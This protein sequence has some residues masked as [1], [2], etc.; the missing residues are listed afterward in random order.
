MKKS[1]QHILTKTY[2]GQSLIE[3]LLAM[4]IA[5]IIFPAVATGIIT[6]REGRVQQRQRFEAIAYMK[7]AHEALRNIRERGWDN[8]NSTGTYSPILNGSTWELTPGS[9]TVDGFTIAIVMS[10]VYRDNGAIVLSTPP[11]I[12]DPSTKRATITVSW[13]T[14]FT[15]SVESTYYLTRYLENDAYIETTLGDF[16]FLNA[17]STPKAYP[18]VKTGVTVNATTSSG[19]PNDGEV[20]LGAGG[21]SD[22]CTPSLLEN[23]LDLPGSGYP[24]SITAIEGKAFAGTGENASGLSFMDIDISNAEPPVATLGNTYDGHKSNEVF[25]EVNYGYI[26]TDTNA[27]EV[28]IIDLTGGTYTEAG[29][30]NA[31][32]N[33]SGDALFVMGNTGYMTAANK[34]YNFDVTSKTGSRPIIDTDGVTL[35]GSG[36]DMYIVNN[37]AYV[38]ISGNTSVEMQIIDLSNP[39]N[40]TVINN[41]NLNSASAKDIYVNSDG[42]RAYIA[43]G[44][45]ASQRE[46]FIVDVDPAS[47]TYLSVMGTFDTNGMDPRGITVVP[48]N[49]LIIVG[50]GGEEYQVVRIENEGSPTYCEGENLD[51]G[52]NSVASILE[53]DGDAYSYIM[54]G[55][56]D[57]EFRVIE[58]GPGGAYAST[59]IFESATF[60]PGYQTANN[61]FSASFSEPSGTE[62]RFQVALTALSGGN[63]PSTGSYTFIGPDGTSAS[64]FEPNSGDSLAFPLSTFGNY[65]NPGQCFRYRAYMTTSNINSTPVL[66]D[67]TINYSP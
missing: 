41:L 56:A 17:D 1:V 5:A 25:G 53:S 55:D 59:G 48:G 2:K 10:E 36:T 19:V 40:L 7:Q 13:D 28:V 47:G 29:Y 42:T 49:R 45:S 30:F 67:F 62:I 57:T 44:A 34:F 26:T 23:T 38:S 50:H 18:G 9:A 52:I 3:L 15:S 58:G 22:W 4:G 37:R 16:N 24:S 60:T 27:K 35:A 63:C 20:V 43:T 6:S 14:P 11:G 66:N 33:G 61:R 65:T 54:T 64:Y 21:S 8:I 31:P 39:S 32:G 12:V 51:S 46:M